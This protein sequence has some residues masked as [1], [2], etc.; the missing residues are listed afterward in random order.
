[1]FESWKTFQGKISQFVREGDSR[2][3]AFVVLIAFL[4]V[5]VSLRFLGSDSEWTDN[6]IVR[7]DIIDVVAEVEGVISAFHFKDNHQVTKDNL[8]VDIRDDVFKTAV[9]VAEAEYQKASDEL[10][11]AKDK[12]SLE[13]MNIESQIIS[14]EAIRDA[15]ASQY[16]TAKLELNELKD[17]LKVSA[18]QLEYSKAD[19]DRLQPLLASQAIS[20]K[21]FDDSLRD[22]NVALSKYNEA[23]S[24]VKTKYSEIKTFESLNK[25]AGIDFNLMKSS[26]EIVSKKLDGEIE[27]AK[28]NIAIAFAK[29]DEAKI[30]LNRTKIPVLREGVITNRRVAIGD[31][32]EVGQPIASITSCGENAWIEANFKET[33]IGKMQVGQKVKVKIDTYPDEQFLG[34]VES[35]STGSGSIFSVLPPENATGNFTKV[36]QRFPVKIK[37]SDNNLGRFKI[38]MSTEVTVDVTN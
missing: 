9:S 17:G 2:L 13:L 32:I 15:T 1:M 16:E 37:I 27:T 34:E 14:F 31:F 23:N 3:K 8:L 4:C 38:G 35:I 10:E 36:V 12:R 19:L 26:K 33:Q 24:K 22:Y 20:K 18:V 30:K 29:L 11:L 7:C 21:I 25:K 5:Y 28:S 6:A